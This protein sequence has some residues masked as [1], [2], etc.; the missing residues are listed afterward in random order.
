M[1]DIIFERIDI[2]AFGGLKNVTL[3][4]SEGVNLVFA[5]NGK[6]KSTVASFI[7]YIFYGFANT[8][9]QTVLGNERAMYM[10][11]DANF[12][13][14]SVTLS[15]EKGRFCVSRS[16]GK[17]SRE[18]VGVTDCST[19][20]RVYE[21]LVPGVVFFG[22]SEDTY[23][24]TAF[25]YSLRSYRN[26]DPALA[27]QIENIMFTADEMTS[28][29]KA[30]SKL[31]EARTAIA[32]RQNRGLLPS[33]LAQLRGVENEL[34]NAT[35]N[36]D[37]INSLT[38]ALKE[39]R[40]K[41]AERDSRKAE[42]DAE[43]DNIERFDSRRVLDEL[44]K[45][46]EEAEQARAELEKQQELFG[47]EIPDQV[48]CGELNSDVGR[49]AADKAQ[50]AL[51]RSELETRKIA[52]E[53]LKER[54]GLTSCDADHAKV[55]RGLG[56]RTAALWWFVALTV[57]SA[58]GFGALAYLHYSGVFTSYML[59]IVAAAAAGGFALL[60]V[61]AAI[62]RGSY[63]HRF[64]C[65]SLRRLRDELREYPEMEHRLN[66]RIEAVKLLESQISSAQSS[67]DS[68]SR[69]ISSRLAAALGSEPSE[70]E[71]DAAVTRL[72]SMTADAALVRSAYERK[73]DAYEFRS[74]AIDAQLLRERAESAVEPQR[75]R[76]QVQ[77]EMRFCEM[78][79][80]DLESQAG[81]L[82]M[83]IA[84]LKEHPHNPSELEAK[85]EVLQ[86]RADELTEKKQAYE[87][88]AE[89]LERA[90]TH[91][92][93]SI[94]PQL[95]ERATKLFCEATGYD[96]S[97][98]GVDT[99]LNVTFESGSGMRSADFLS[100]GTRDTAYLCLRLALID[101]ICREGRPPVVF[102]DAFCHLDDR[103]MRLMLDVLLSGG[104][105]QCFI[106]TCRDNELKYLKEKN[107]PAT[108]LEL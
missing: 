24:K 32:N 75:D 13:E 99:A 39:K 35:R 14:G 61:I 11:W 57:I 71:Y 91:M 34:Y 47:G 37:E 56:R 43:L 107:A 4:P 38:A 7:K 90:S 20:K 51:L 28:Y 87:L 74:A 42:L 78:T 70:E 15:C 72:L 26:G 6:G 105:G 50:L 106:F 31:S 101:M 79:R 44:D 64:G 67:L 76:A 27:Q 65:R 29:D 10:P 3:T 73:R 102:D 68:L 8:R 25:L 49:F 30:A 81:E 84:K 66:E 18:S 82:E 1:K 55:R 69:S 77:R 108:L 100:D 86:A 19:G 93:S 17:G 5:A 95:T 83:R 36:N 53:E 62:V 2:V 33:V 98:L 40:A 23:V 85:R 52:F 80:Q 46:R 16:Y 21:G 59:N 12:V 63:A 92:R 88:A 96:H 54:S 103:R 58:A 94:A 41:I 9:Q 48:K 97:A 60:S 22:V 45:F 104:A 89:Y